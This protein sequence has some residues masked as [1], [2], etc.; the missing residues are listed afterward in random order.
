MENTV[1]R[2]RKKSKWETMYD[3]IHTK[4]LEESRTYLTYPA[5]KLAREWAT[6]DLKADRTNLIEEEFRYRIMNNSN[7]VTRVYGVQGSGKSFVSIGL[8]FRYIEIVE[9]IMGFRPK[10]F[11]T[12]NM[13]DTIKTWLEMEKWDIVMEDEAPILQGVNSSIIQRNYMNMLD[14]ERASNK[15]LFKNSPRYG[16]ISGIAFSLETFG[17]DSKYNITKDPK[18]MLTHCKIWYPLLQPSNVHSKVPLGHA[19][20]PVGLEG[21]IAIHKEYNDAK[22]AN[23]K[24]LEENQGAVGSNVNDRVKDIVE[25]MKKVVNKYYKGQTL[26]K[27]QLKVVLIQLNIPI[28]TTLQELAITAFQMSQNQNSEDSEDSED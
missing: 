1:N 13:E 27:K 28:S 6:L 14:Q 21:A 7:V 24:H 23:I 8:A 12:F 3:E 22:M 25:K 10:F 4:Q 18:D 2:E 5:L 11:F 16:Y 17:F 15:G 26:T 19:F 20:I 9:E